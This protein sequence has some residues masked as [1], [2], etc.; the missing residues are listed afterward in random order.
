MDHRV[1]QAVS[2]TNLPRQTL[3]TC[4]MHMSGGLSDHLIMYGCSVLTYACH[5]GPQ[6][7]IGFACTSRA[8]APSTAAAALSCILR[9]RPKPLLLLLLDLLRPRDTP[10]VLCRPYKAPINLKLHPA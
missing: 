3:E 6:H 9:D 7:A 2:M 1:Q 8:S 4:I 10:H 5:N